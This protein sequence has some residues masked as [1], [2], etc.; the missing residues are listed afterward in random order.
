[1]SGLV[2]FGIGL[3]LLG[4]GLLLI[5]RFWPEPA[6]QSVR[7]M[8]WPAPAVEST[9]AVTRYERSI[10]WPTLVDANAG[11]L[12]LDERRNI[13]EMLALVGEP[14]CADILAHAYPQ[15]Q[16]ALREAVIDAIGRSAGEVLPTLERAY[17][18][19]RV[20]ERYAVIDAASRRGDV[21]LLTRGLRDS[22]GTVGLAAAYGLVRAK[23][24][25]LIEAA[26][27]E[28]E[29]A[30]ANEIRRTLLVLT[31]PT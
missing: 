28:R 5:A 9:G 2:I 11:E 6:M 12:S 13:I 24:R 8:V 20:A 27:A 26:L 7:A 21:E 14:W 30:R 22:D 17:R 18:S 19:H 4:S 29:D 10:T 15:E 16:D 3:I 25:D 31:E 1:M 23:R